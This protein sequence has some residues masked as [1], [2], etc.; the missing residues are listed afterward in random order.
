M[1]LALMIIMYM[2]K[3][4]KSMNKGLKILWNKLSWKK[5]LKRPA[6]L[7][8]NN[9]ISSIWNI[10]KIKLLMS[11]GKIFKMLMMLRMMMMMTKMMNMNMRLMKNM[12]M[13]KNRKS[14]GNRSNKFHGVVLLLIQI[15]VLVPSKIDRQ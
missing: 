9:S 12:R 14:K 3:S 11:K 8:K 7:Q 5:K 10:L 6:R 1:K 15:L 13:K 2:I 4:I